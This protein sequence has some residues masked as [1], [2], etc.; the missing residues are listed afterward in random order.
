MSSDNPEVYLSILDLYEGMLP[1][2]NRAASKYSCARKGFLTCL[3][4]Y[5][6]KKH[7]ESCKVP[8]P[9]YLK[10]KLAELEKGDV[11]ITLNWDTIVERT[12]LRDNLWAPTDGYGFRKTLV[13]C[14]AHGGTTPIPNSLRTSQIRVLKLH[15]SVGWYWNG[16][17]L[18]FHNKKFL[19]H[20]PL[21]LKHGAQWFDPSPQ[22]Q[23]EKPSLI[24][25]TYLKKIE[26]FEIQQVWHR[27]AEAL[28]KANV[29]EVWGYSL[30]E[31]DG[32]IRALLNTL[33]FRREVEI[34]VHEP[35]VAA[36]TRWSEFLRRS[37]G[38]ILIDSLALGTV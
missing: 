27:A 6:E 32:A 26:G 1:L 9:P 24:Y 18:Y 2:E 33:P 30:P 22:P 8:P 17:R 3:S 19:Q 14:M 10:E 12:L 13:V 35:C 23:D 5:F 28:R 25:P 4:S 36:Q 34:C 38:T 21:S 11:V 37:T 29:V 31:S 15:G 7:E 20:F 16:C